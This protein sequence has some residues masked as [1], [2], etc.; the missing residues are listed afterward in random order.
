MKPSIGRIVHYY[1][2]E[3]PKARAA[4][5]TEVNKH[6]G[7]NLTVFDSGYTFFVY[8]I[9]HVSDAGDGWWDWPPRI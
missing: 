7:V 1:V 6:D 8:D 9:H 3:Y 2:N 4:I 5:I